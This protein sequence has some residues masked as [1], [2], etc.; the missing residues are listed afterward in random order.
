MG[1]DRDDSKT[2]EASHKL[3]RQFPFVRF[4]SG[5]QQSNLSV[6]YY[7]PLALRSTGKFVQL[8]NDDTLFATKGWNIVA[9]ELLNS[10]QKHPDGILL[11]CPHDDTGCA[12]SCFPVLSR[13]AI[14]ALGHAINPAFGSWGGDVQLDMVFAAL[15]RKVP[16]PYD[17][18]HLCRHNRTRGID[19][20]QARMPR[21]T[22]GYP[23]E[24]TVKNDT[25]RLRK[26]I[27]E[28]TR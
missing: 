10:F 28:N 2:V 4:F 18:K 9:L 20:V 24:E 8:L 26:I 5:E 13:Q 6:G 17:I 14:L 15:G 21:L 27:D 11:G 16:L 25:E 12:Y 19:R 23:Y 7:T 1:I 3:R 22:R